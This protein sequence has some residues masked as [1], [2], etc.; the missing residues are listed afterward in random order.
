M[1]FV[2][3]WAQKKTTRVEEDYWSSVENHLEQEELRLDVAM[4]KQEGSP[5]EGASAADR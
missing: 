2:Q 5:L 3:R 4:I 1:G